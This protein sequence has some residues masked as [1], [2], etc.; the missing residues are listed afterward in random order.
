MGLEVVDFQA[1]LYLFHACVGCVMMSV[2]RVMSWKNQTL[3]GS[4]QVS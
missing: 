4:L 3:S 1:H 2:D